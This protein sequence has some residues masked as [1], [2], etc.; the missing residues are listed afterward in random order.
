LYTTF[1]IDHSQLTRPF[2]VDN[3][4]ENNMPFLAKQHVPIPTKDILSW[5]F[6]ELSYGLDKPIYIDA[7]DPSRY[8]TA[9]TARTLIQQLAA[10]FRA[11]G[12]RPG[13]CVSI[14]SFND[15]CYPLFFLGLIAAGGIFAGTNP[16][17]TAHEL[18]HVLKTARVKYVLTQPQFLKSV[19]KATQATGIPRERVIIFNPKGEDAPDGFAHW[20]DLLKHGESDWIRFDSYNDSYNAGAARLFSSGTTG[21]PKAAELS[22][23]NL[24]AQHTLAVEIEKRPYEIRRLVALPLFHAAVAPLTFC[25]PLRQGESTYI[26]PRFDLE[27]WLEAQSKYQ[28]T[29]LAAVPPI[30]VLAVNSP[31]IEKFSLKS[32]R[33]A[34]CGAAPLDKDMQARL[35]KY[36][37]DDVPFTQVWGMT[38]LSCMCTRHPWPDHD[39][40]GSI[41]VPLP[42]IDVK[43]VDDDG[44]DITAYGVRGEI[45]IRGPTVIRGYFEN[46]GANKRDWDEDGFF[47]TGDICYVDEKTGFYYIVDRKKVG[48]S[49]RTIPPGAVLTWHLLMH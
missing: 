8:Y 21:L 27:T 32:I 41:G 42:N 16:A 34:A 25:T 45:C 31:L 23:Y 26:F 18:A 37:K 7:Q 43:L 19:L 29:E 9:R 38:E 17:Y 39:T 30:V 10:G 13:D 49:F 3:L 46:P 22:H 20:Q 12:V 40:T 33:M 24:I 1:A 11:I 35:K 2:G 48:T 4:S 47:H 36:L 28:I 5:T 44:R 14:H 6:D 15:I